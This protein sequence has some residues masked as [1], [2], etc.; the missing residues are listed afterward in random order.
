M[1]SNCF[2]KYKLVYGLKIT[3][4]QVNRFLRVLIV[5]SYAVAQVIVQL[6]SFQVG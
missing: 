4:I 5:Y 1:F 6:K 2:F 3:I